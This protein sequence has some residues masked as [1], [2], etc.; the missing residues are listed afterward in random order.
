MDYLTA[1]F[2]QIDDFCK[3]FEPKFNSKL[4]GNKKIRNRATCISTAEIITVWIAFH[5]C[6]MRDFKTYYLWQVKTIWQRDFPHMPSYNRFVELAQRVLP[7]MVVFLS[8]QMGE[9]TGIGVVDATALPVCHNRRIRSHKVFKNIAQRGKT[10]TGWFYGFKLH[11][12]FNHLGQLVNFYITAG[13]VDDRV[14]LK[15]MLGKIF[16]TLVGDRGYISKELSHYLEKEYGIT[17]LTGARKNMKPKNHTPEQVKL[18]KQ[19]G[20]VE[21][22]F[23]Q[24]KNLCQIEH[25]RHRS[26]YG[27]LLNLISGL[28][29]YCLFAYK[30]LMFGK[31]SLLPMK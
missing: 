12:I 4:I 27:F 7:A 11:A 14:G 25:T 20:F 9:C 10:S 17:L 29:A 23:D 5:H 3:N 24:L 6:R 28:T 26:E 13:N 8:T 15:K 21:T 22:I 1:L 31:K 2:C 18:L 19:R 16:G 30:P